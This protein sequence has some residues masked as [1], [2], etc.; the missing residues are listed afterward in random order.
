[1]NEIEQ[2]QYKLKNLTSLID[3]TSIISSTLDLEELMN[4]VMEKAQEV[5]SAEASS[6]MLLNE[7]SGMLECQIALG[8]VQ[9]K[10][11]DKMQLKVGQGIAGWV[12]QTGESVIVP[13][14]STDT[15]F[16]SD[17]DQ[18]TGFKTKSILAAPLKVKGK[19]IGVAEVINRLDS[20]P[21][22][23]ENLEIFTTFCRQVALAI[24][25]ARMHRFMLEQQRMEQQLESAHQIQQSFMPQSFPD[26]ENDKYLI[27]GTNIPATAVG[28]DLFDFVEIDSD[29]LGIVLGDVSGKGIPAAL[30]MARLISDFRYYCHIAENPVELLNFLNDALLKRSH[31]GMFVTLVFM[32]LNKETGHLIIS[33]AG[34]LP[35]LWYR[36]RHKKVEIVDLFSGIP[37]GIMPDVD[38]NEYMIQMEPGDALLL[39]T[40]GVTEAKNSKKEMFS[41][42][43]LIDIFK[44]PKKKPQ[45]IIDNIVKEVRGFQGTGN[46]H[47]DITLL[48]VR[49]QECKKS[50]LQ[51]LIQSK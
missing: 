21:F 13:D 7:E 1:M 24:E 37:L 25:N 44:K 34:H 8:S 28:G 18:N 39:F 50:K 36:Q 41:L 45:L 10:V 5:M 23:D 51:Q 27:Y 2:L 22:T 11:K 15:R 9:E 33:N 14:V 6:I 26:S 40:D 4:L 12:A 49:W 47:D 46:Q 43:R 32:I 20:L 29:H 17:V 48:A 35:P 42:N 19:V 16:F 31:R 30:F 38:Y 3:V